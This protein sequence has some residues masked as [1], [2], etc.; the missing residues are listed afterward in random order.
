[1]RVGNNPLKGKN[2]TRTSRFVACVCTHLPNEIGYHEKRFEVIK[3]SLETMRAGAGGA[4]IVV[5]DN[6]SCDKL[7]AWLINDYKPDRLILSDNV[8]KT[9]ARKSVFGMY[10]DETAIAF[11]DD[12]MFYYPRWFDK[13]YELLSSFPNV[14]AVTGY[15]VRTAFRWGISAT[16][17][18]AQKNAALDKGRFISEQEERDFCV[19]IGRDWDFH[20]KYTENDMDYLVTYNGMTA[21]ATAHHCQMM[22]YAGKLFPLMTWSAEA[23][24]DEKPFD[25]AINNNGMLR[26]ATAERCTRHIGNVIDDGIR[27]AQKQYHI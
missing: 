27:A 25:N 17:E 22:G 15:P 21:Y 9:S 18:W 12:D 1:M 24:Q 8:G 20:K 3:L 23:L 16:L 2:A 7:R 19:S 4:E 13:Q 14:G 10:P 5:W 26:L 6:G 11:A